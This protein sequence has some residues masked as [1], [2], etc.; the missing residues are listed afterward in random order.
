MEHLDAPL[1][2]QNVVW[3]VESILH[4]INVSFQNCLTPQSPQAPQ[5]PHITL[6]LRMH[7]KALLHAMEERERAS[8]DGIPYRNTHSY[9]NY[10]VLG[11]E[12]GS[13]KS[14][15]V[16]AYISQMKSRPFS[17]PVQTKLYPNSHGNFFTVYKKEYKQSNGPNLIVVPHTIYRQWQEY[18]KKQ[19]TLKVFYA[20]TQKSIDTLLKETVPTELSGIVNGTSVHSDAF[21]AMLKEIKE[22]D[23][24]LVGNTLYHQ[25]QTAAKK[26][27]IYWR[28]VFIDEADSIHIPSGNASLL[29]PF[30]WFITATWPNFLFDGHTIR[31]RMLEYYESHPE[32]FTHELGQWL[33]EEVGIES[34][35]GG[36]IGRSTLLR[37][38]SSRW[39]QEFYSTNMLRGMVLLV[40]S[41][42]FLQESRQMPPIVYTTLLCEQPATH[43]ALRG[44]VNTVIQ[45][46]LHAGNVEGALQ[47][48]GVSTNTSTNLIEAVTKE[49]EKELDRLKK[50][51]AFKETMEYATQQSKELA[52][53]TLQSKIHS[54]EEQL[55]TFRERLTNLNSEDCPICYEDPRKHSGTLTPCCHRIFCG[56]C[57]VQSLTR[58]PYC[59][60]CR[61][62][63]RPNQLVQLVEVE[64]K[65][66]KK[67][68][69]LL[70][71]QKQLLDF[72]KKEPNSRV[73]VF[74]RY[75]NPFMYLEQG[76][77]NE[78]IPYHTLRGNKDTIAST[79]RSFERGEKRVLFL[80]TDSCGVGLNLVSATHVVLFHAM[81][82]E[83]EK[84]VVGRAYRLGRTEP[85]QVIRLLHDGESIS[86]IQT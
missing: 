50:T 46:M 67:E 63:I 83:E 35:T 64:A 57:I 38:R 32:L 79:I 73:L 86:N 22:S 42:S 81:T 33:R 19:T 39:L 23:I 4:R 65:V 62:T 17:N 3:T 55:K 72:L 60:M 25:L 29:C 53:A 80:S 9:T 77:T 58:T 85:L 7:Q 36:G 78:G 47:E 48:L 16:L 70:T 10:A 13:G 56:G 34:Y 52:L 2:D 14:L 49:R 68:V 28:R 69:V 18:C 6:P 45:S 30:V 82:P 84:Q 75:E 31:P 61:A 41:S 15:T 8:I 5:P 11:D 21:V 12:V 26:C 40:C 74:S 43:R 59:P 54:V 71:K 20:K 51:L 37:S 44:I 24:V 27:G 66:P 1:L 76:C